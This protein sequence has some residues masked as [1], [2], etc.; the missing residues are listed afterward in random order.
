[1]TEASKIYAELFK[2]ATSSAEVQQ[3]VKAVDEGLLH[4]LMHNPAAWAIFGGAGA[5]IPTYS[6]GRAQGI[7]QGLDERTRTR[8]LAFGAGFGTG[9]ITPSMLKALGRSA[10]I[11]LTPGGGGSQEFTSI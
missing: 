9:L 1:M 10:G 2:L 4:K 6:L 7:H 11:G 3:V 5:A 8:N